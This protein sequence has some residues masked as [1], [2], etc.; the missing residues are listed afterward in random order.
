MATA[1]VVTKRTVESLPPILEN[2]HQSTIGERLAQKVLEGID[3]AQP[4][5][6][7]A[8][9][10]IVRRRQQLPLR[11]DT[12]D[13]AVS[14]KLEHADFA[15]LEPMAKQVMARQFFGV[16]GRTAFSQIAR[17]GGRYEALGPLGFAKMPPAAADRSNSATLWQLSERLTGVTYR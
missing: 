8:N 6:G 7:R 2:W 10:Q 14:M 16:S 3:D 11:R 13:T 12:H 5:D 15:T 9:F 4:V 1:A 17:G